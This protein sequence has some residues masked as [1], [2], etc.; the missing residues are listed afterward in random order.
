MYVLNLKD[1]PLC[2]SPRTRTGKSRRIEVISMASDEAHLSK[3]ASSATV[4]EL[5]ELEQPL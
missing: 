1:V 2:P 3:A 5:Q 4:R